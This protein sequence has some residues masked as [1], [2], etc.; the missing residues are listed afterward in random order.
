MMH[1]IR[2]ERYSAAH[3]LCRENWTEEENLSVFGP[4]SH[5]NWHGHNYELFI[6]V[7][8][9]IDPETGFVINLKDLSKIVKHK[10]IDKVD[11]RNLNLDVDFLE[12]K[13]TTS[14][15]IAVAMWEE[16][17]A[18]ISAF[19]CSLHCVKLVETENNMVEYYGK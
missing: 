5:P 7:K 17:E 11:H 3:K 6:T 18:D 1:I 8:G 2:R 10:I 19:G 12:G 9:D 4:C 14:E 13:V 15:N 16:I